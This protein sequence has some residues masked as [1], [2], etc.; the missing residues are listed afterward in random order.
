MDGHT[1]IASAKLSGQYG[2]QAI[3]R[4][5]V[6]LQAQYYLPQSPLWL[7][8]AAG[9]VDALTNPDPHEVLV[10]GGEDGMRGYPMHYQSGNRRA[11]FTVEERFYT[12][13]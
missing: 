5:R 9:S 6:G 1:L 10:L 8:Y 13:G 7:F 12:D 11:L 2:G 3:H 4:Q